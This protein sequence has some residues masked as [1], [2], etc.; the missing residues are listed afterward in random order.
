MTSDSDP[1][2]QPDDV[3]AARGGGAIY[4]KI[5]IGSV[6]VQLLMVLWQICA[7]MIYDTHIHQH[8][9]NMS[10][11]DYSDWVTKLFEWGVIFGPF[12]AQFLLWPIALTTISTVSKFSWLWLGLATMSVLLWWVG[13]YCSSLALGCAVGTFD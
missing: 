5:A 8:M 10:R 3:A 7:I 1:S 11:P 2:R 6:T 13:W 4:R 9:P 12:F